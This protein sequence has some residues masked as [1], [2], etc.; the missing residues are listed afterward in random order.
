MDTFSGKAVIL[1]PQNYPKGN[2]IFIYRY[3]FDRQAS[4][5]CGDGTCPGLY[6]VSWAQWSAAKPSD[7][8]FDTGGGAF[9]YMGNIDT[10]GYGQISPAAAI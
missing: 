6:Y 9:H 10:V 1:R 8:S 4:F 7:A 2:L 5:G 3:I